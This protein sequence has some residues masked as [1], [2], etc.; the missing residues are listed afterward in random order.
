MKDDSI[1]KTGKHS[2]FCEGHV[3]CP[4]THKEECGKVMIFGVH[5]QG[6]AP[7]QVL[8]FGCGEQHRVSEGDQ[9]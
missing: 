2:Q 8:C 1:G 4:T 7:V 6:T 3:S 5:Q 9:K